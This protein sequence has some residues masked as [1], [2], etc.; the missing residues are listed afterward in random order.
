MLDVVGVLNR[1][2]HHEP[3]HVELVARGIAQVGPQP[4]KA[5]GI[6]AIAKMI[7]ECPSLV[8]TGERGATAQVCSEHGA[9]TFSLALGTVSVDVVLR[10]DEKALAD[11]VS[12]T[13]VDSRN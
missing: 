1:M 5:E 12:W 4:P 8:A 13:V 3:I 9:I 6:R 11:A 7:A 2:H 10:A